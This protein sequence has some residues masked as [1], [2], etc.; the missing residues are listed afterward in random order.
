M[1]GE[2]FFDGD[3]LTFDDVLLLPGFSEILPRDADVS[4]YLTSKIKLNIP[5]I[6]SPMDTVTTSRMAIAMAME[7]GIGIIHRNLSIERQAE[8]VDRVKRYES[9]MISDPVTLGENKTVF[10]AMTLMEKY[11]ISGIPVVAG[12]KLIGIVTA[13]DIRFVKDSHK[14]LVSDVMTRKV[15]T[16]EVGIKI[17]KAKEILHKYR[18]EKLP[19]VDK[20]GV[21]KGLLTYKDILKAEKFPNS[22]KD[23]RGRL[24]VGA[25]VGVGADL[26]DRIRALVEFGADVVVV[27]SS[28]GMSKK[29]VET[30]GHIKSKYSDVE[31]IAGNVAT[32]EGAKLLVEAGADG[33]R[34]GMGPG[35]ICTTRIVSGMGVPQITAIMECVRAASGK[36]IPV[37]ADGGIRYSGDIVKAIV[38]GASSVMAGSLFAGCEESPGELIV[39]GGQAFKEYRGMGSIGAMKEGGAERYGQKYQGSAAKLVPEG[40]EGR[41]SFKGPLSNIVYQM[42]GGLRSGM[43]YAGAKNIKQMQESGKFI[44]ITQASLAESHPHDIFIT[45]EPPNYSR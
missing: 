19:L 39:T 11:H 20:K 37:I 40:V 45:K 22:S 38:A 42:V 33:I 13:R 26:D 41:V 10:E 27:D 28:H 44:R 30:V 2:K 8:E 31:L 17:E 14:T 32:Y 16:A 36:N 34:V 3:G 12:S 6:S 9:G 5:F 21:L 18:I 35:S 15:I 7:G 24:M 29:V 43:G 4:T 25:A 23:E 1:E